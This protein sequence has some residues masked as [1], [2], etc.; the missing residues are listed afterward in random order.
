VVNVRGKSIRDV[1]VD[2]VDA[3]PRD[4]KG[5]GSPLVALGHRQDTF[6]A[7]KKFFAGS[8]PKIEE[9]SLIWPM[10][11]QGTY[12]HYYLP[13]PLCNPDNLSNRIFKIE[14]EDIKWSKDNI[15]A[16][17][18]YPV[19]VWLECPH[20]AGR[21]EESQKTWMLDR[22]RWLA[23]DEETGE[24][25]EPGYDVEH[26]SLRLPSFYSPLGFFSWHDAVKTFFDYKKSL[27]PMEY[28]AFLNQVCALTFSLAG[29]TINDRALAS[30]IEEYTNADTG[31]IV[32]APDGVLAI[33]AGVDI[34]KDR[35]EIEVVGWG[36]Y[37]E[38]WSL[39]YQVFWGPTDLTGDQLYNDPVTGEPTSWGQLD[40]Y[41]KSR[42]RHA[43]GRMMPIENTLV[44]A[45]YRPES[46]H[47]YCR[48][49]E[50][51][52][53]WPSLGRIRHGKGYIIRPQKRTTWGTW[54]VEINV[55]LVKDCLYQWFT[56][57]KPGS[58]Y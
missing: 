12:E 52:R 43:S 4:V 48:E 27:D 56:I 46:V 41:H 38:S 7:V 13:C 8:T 30:H 21:I 19:D 20:C 22:G 47:A 5:E 1:A 29:R 18:G 54:C 33:T 40:Q 51:R 57:E 3:F 53:I 37:Y 14:F 26:V 58:G 16:Q 6:S 23:E 35:I 9:T 15:D 32:D 24:L 39:D 28:Q 49:N 45:G 42:F 10:L 50:G 31:E 34:Q 36:L 11:E 17:T 55:D 25:Y 2:E 44:D